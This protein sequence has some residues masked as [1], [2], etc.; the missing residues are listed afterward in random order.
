MK[1]IN[2]PRCKGCGSVPGTDFFQAPCHVCK[3]CGKVDQKSE[4]YIKY[5]TPISKEK[6]NVK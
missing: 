1:K 5:I 4:N 3:G 6:T 2:C